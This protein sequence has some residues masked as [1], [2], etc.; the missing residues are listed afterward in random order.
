[1]GYRNGNRNSGNGGYSPCPEH[2][3]QK[4]YSLHVV[5]PCR[6][7]NYLLEPHVFRKEFAISG[8]NL[9]GKIV[10]LPLLVAPAF[11]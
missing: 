9:S 11:R 1:M 7:S 2:I 4:L 8:V 5:V 6:I 10:A 3:K